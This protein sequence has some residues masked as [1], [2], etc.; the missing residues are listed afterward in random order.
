[1]SKLKLEVGKSYR[2]RKGEVIEIIGRGGYGLR[3]YIDSG[4]CA[5]KADGR[6][7]VGNSLHPYDLVEEVQPE[8]KRRKVKWPIRGRVKRKEASEAIYYTPDEVERVIGNPPYP[9]APESFGP[10]ADAKAAFERA[11]DEYEAEPEPPELTFSQAEY[12]AA[13]RLAG[14]DTNRPDL[15]Y[16]IAALMQETGGDPT[17]QQLMGGME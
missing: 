9:D 12:A 1:M 8:P 6:Y 2:N 13:L 16:R 14:I 5:Y 10:M 11:V 3:A 7:V 17:M 15:F 4:G